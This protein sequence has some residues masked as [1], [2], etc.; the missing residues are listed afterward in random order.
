MASGHI[1]FFRNQEY[2]SYNVVIANNVFHQPNN[3]DGGQQ[4]TAIV[5]GNLNSKTCPTSSHIDPNSTTIVNNVTNS[6]Y[7]FKACENEIKASGVWSINTELDN[8]RSD[9]GMTDPD[10]HDFRPTSDADIL[11][12]KASATYAPKYDYLGNAR[13]S[14]DKD[15]GAFENGAQLGESESA[16][17]PPQGLKVLQ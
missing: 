9:T 7:M 12:G 8:R 10:N 5:A 13:P 3:N 15:I 11:L 16:P 14:G 4:D 2:R 1:T 17:E 6:R